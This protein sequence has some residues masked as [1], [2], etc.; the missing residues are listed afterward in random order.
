MKSGKILDLSKATFSQMRSSSK[1]PFLV[2]IVL[3]LRFSMKQQ[4]IDQNV[5]KYYSQ[6]P[7]KQV[8]LL[9]YYHVELLAL[10]RARS[11]TLQ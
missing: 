11:Q 2:E 8:Y 9:N 1:C 7:N 4:F 6:V 5:R 3:S 10:T